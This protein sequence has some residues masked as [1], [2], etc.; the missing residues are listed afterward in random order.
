MMGTA[1]KF[2]TRVRNVTGRQISRASVLFSKLHHDHHRMEMTPT[3]KSSHQRLRRR[4]V[5]IATWVA[6]AVSLSPVKLQAPAVCAKSARGEAY[7][8]AVCAREEHRSDEILLRTARER[9]HC[10]SFSVAS[11]LS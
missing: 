1:L 2:P 8:S 11:D 9:S 5:V 4:Q 7:N 6:S 3:I 10:S